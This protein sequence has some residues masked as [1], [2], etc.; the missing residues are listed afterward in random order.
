MSE[1]TLLMGLI[2]GHIL[3]DFYLQPNV[4]VKQRLAKHYKSPDLYYHV[5]VHGVITLC[6]FVLLSKQSVLACL[7]YSFI[8]MS[9]HLVID[10]VKSYSKQNSVT[11]ILDQLAHLVIL[12]IIWA[13]ATN[14]LS[15]VSSLLSTNH[16][17]YQQAAVI[18]GYLLILKPTSIVITILLSPWS[19]SI[20]QQADGTTQTQSTTTT[21]SDLQSAGKRIGYLERILIITFILLNQFSAIGFLLAAKSV[22]R[23]GDLS[24]DR[25]KK[26]TEYVMLGTLTSFTITILIGLGVAAIVSQLPIG[27]SK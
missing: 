16:I 21:H 18:I 5:A 23:F 12:I 6:I 7:L 25:D 26:M 15:E 11:F 22:F 9:S 20:K 4:W 24:R 10:I 13:M 17:S 2:I 27:Q 3:G 14:T 8:V 19:T 1:L